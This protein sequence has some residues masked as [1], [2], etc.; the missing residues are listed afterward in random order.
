[1]NLYFLDLSVNKLSEVPGILTEFP[2]IRII[3]LSYNK[4]TNMEIF[5]KEK[6]FTHL[7]TIDVSNN[8]IE[9]VSE[10]VWNRSGSLNFLNL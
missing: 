10:S 2:R 3:H 8:Q 7:E 5:F 1:M 9:E 6:A 4:I